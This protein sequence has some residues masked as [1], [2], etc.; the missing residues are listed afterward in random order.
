MDLK[1]TQI[2]KLCSFYVSDWHLVT[3]L[4]PYINKKVNEEAKIAT[5]LEKNLKQNIVTLVEKLN[6]KNKEQI[7][8]LNWEKNENIKDKLNQLKENEEFIIL[9]NG[10]EKFIKEQNK[11]IEKYFKTHLLKNKI[12][13]IDCYE[14]TQY[15]GSISKI[16][17][18]HDK[19]LNTAGEKEIEEIFPEYKNQENR[20]VV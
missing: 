20:K 14:V 12:K 2:L 16:L 6:L 18:E 19:I 8:K 3:M 1:Q 11:K 13:I 15:N 5:I 10:N 7:L 9:I 4:L 17:D